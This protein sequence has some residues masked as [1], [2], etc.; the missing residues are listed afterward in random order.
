[1]QNQIITIKT[2][3]LTNYASSI[4]KILYNANSTN[5]TENTVKG[6]CYEHISLKHNNTQ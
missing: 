4:N 2:M 3:F 5:L 1:M 6:N